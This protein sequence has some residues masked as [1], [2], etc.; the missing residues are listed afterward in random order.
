[1]EYID[2]PL[3][4]DAQGFK[5]K[6]LSF[7]QNLHIKKINIVIIVF[8]LE[9]NIFD[10]IVDDNC[11]LLRITIIRNADD[12]SAPRLGLRFRPCVCEK[13]ALSVALLYLSPLHHHSNDKL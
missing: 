11:S 9:V 7:L 6:V 12:H 8:G 5:E 13:T 3:V 10:I 2:I 4:L 1:M